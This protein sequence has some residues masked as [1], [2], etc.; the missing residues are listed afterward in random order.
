[1]HL[2][3]ERYLFGAHIHFIH[4]LSDGIRKKLWLKVVVKRRLCISRRIVWPLMSTQLIFWCQIQKCNNKAI[5]LVNRLLFVVRKGCKVWIPFELIFVWQPIGSEITVR[6]VS[7]NWCRQIRQIDAIFPH[8]MPERPM[9]TRSQV[10]VLSTCLCIKLNA[11][12]TWSAVTQNYFNIRSLKA[13]SHLILF[14]YDIE[15]ACNSILPF[16]SI[17][18]NSLMFYSAQHHCNHW[19]LKSSLL[20]KATLKRNY[21]AA[22]Y[23]FR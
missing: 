8:R 6:V 22:I 5:I 7:S 4:L 19:S 16:D 11:H 15:I 17:S 9:H 23:L 13:M 1:M 18:Y 21:L 12:K 14:L 3:S 2:M 10:S 20:S